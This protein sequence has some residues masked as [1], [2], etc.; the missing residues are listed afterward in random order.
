[1]V[2]VA[3]MLSVF[4]DP[5]LGVATSL[6]EKVGID[7]NIYVT[8]GAWPWVFIITNLWKAVGYN[9]IIYYAAI[10][11][12]DKSYYEAAEIDG[13]S[14]WQTVRYITLPLIKPT[15]IVLVLLA[16]GK[17]FHN[18]FGMFYFLPQDIGVLYSTTQVLDTFVYK[19]MRSSMDIGQASAVALYQSVVGFVLVIVSNKLARK[20]DRE[21]ALF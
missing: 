17:I 11:G 2:V 19:T 16:L 5:T 9:T 7:L 14:K 4:F 1:M 12:I 21:S 10:I 20:Y 18:D 15:V 3:Y 6:L 13:A 8:P